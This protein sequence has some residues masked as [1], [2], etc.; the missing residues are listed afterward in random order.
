ML[1]YEE[2]NEKNKC[3]IVNKIEF[4]TIH[5]LLLTDLESLLIQNYETCIDILCE[6]VDNIIKCR[7]TI[8]SAF[9]QNTYGNLIKVAKNEFNLD[10]K[11]ATHYGKNIDV[12]IADYRQTI[13]EMIM[14]IFSEV[15]NN[16]Y[17]KLIVSVHK[18]FGI[19]N[20][21]VVYT[22]I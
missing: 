15:K 1:N 2:T 22:K 6:S 18:K 16:L 13:N 9:K 12:T 8:M 7:V 11:N 5:H 17:T 3:F 21:N 19:V 10:K 20:V 4:N 14:P